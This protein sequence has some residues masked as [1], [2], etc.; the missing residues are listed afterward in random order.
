MG[1]PPEKPKTTGK[2]AFRRF[3]TVNILKFELTVVC[4]KCNVVRGF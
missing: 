3:V 2:M 1:K 4:I